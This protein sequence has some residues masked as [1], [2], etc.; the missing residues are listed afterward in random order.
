MRMFS[1][2][3]LLAIGFSTGFLLGKFLEICFI[4]DF[5]IPLGITSTP[6]TL[7]WLVLSIATLFLAIFFGCPAKWK[8]RI[9]H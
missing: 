2:E 1:W 4:G 9:I 7:A 3:L 5:R 8:F 6:F